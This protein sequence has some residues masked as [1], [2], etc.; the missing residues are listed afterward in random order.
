MRMIIGLILLVGIAF[1]L[2]GS[3]P[4][5]AASPYRMAIVVGN[6]LATPSKTPLNYAELDAKRIANVL[7]ELGRIDKVKLLL[8]KSADD[9]RAVFSELEQKA[10]QSD[11][12]PMMLFYY[13]GHADDKSLM[14]GNTRFSFT[15]L[16]DKL[17][18]FPADAA[19][20]FIDACQSGQI[21]RTKG[22]KPIPA[23]DVQFDGGDYKG[24]VYITSSAEKENSQESDELK[25][26]FF[27]HY[28]LGGLR[29][30]ADDSGDNRVSLEEA[31]QF[32]YRH[33][34]ARTTNTLRGPQHPSYYTE[35]AGKG[36]LVLTWLSP[37]KS[38]L[39]L[40]KHVQGTYYVRQKN[41]GEVVAEVI[42]TKQNRMRLVLGPGQ[43]EVRKVQD[44]HH[45]VQDVTVIA[46]HETL[47]DESHM[48]K[49]NPELA[50][51]KYGTDG[52]N[53]LFV[54]YNFDTGY[55]QQA[56]FI[57]GIGLGYA[58]TIGPIE[59]GARI[60]Y[61]RSAYMRDDQIDIGL[62][63][64]TA[65]ATLDWRLFRWQWLRLV[66]GLD[67]GA[68]WVWQKGTYPNDN[69]E[70]RSQPVFRYQVRGGIEIPIKR[71]AFLG[72]WAHIG[73]V[74]VEKESGFAAPFVT[75][76]ITGLF[77]EM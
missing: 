41:T 1:L 3:C 7:S 17:K 45:L 73:Q 21:A 11:N 60:G 20:A 34:L 2:V 23:V 18:H 55:L 42:K 68:S 8:G 70:N 27:T 13:S 77:V 31:Y 24:R 22:G 69:V 14:M 25:A 57:H 33:T 39:V 75:G 47:L 66:T 28:L 56:G 6:N 59:I 53:L 37:Y 44:D 74:V 5:K 38:Y 51:A 4:A 49:R 58:H 10:R 9:L 40:P 76:M 35:L 32:A 52:E 67:V 62:H 12:N 65:A 64:V 36:Q 29:G 71:P 46:S 50:S 63:Q 19:I 16:R 48:E 30:A 43:Y 72:L 61:G 15:E 26:S 54:S